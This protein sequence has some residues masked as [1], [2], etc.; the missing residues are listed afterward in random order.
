MTKLKGEIKVVKD[1]IKNLY[2]EKVDSSLEALYG[3]EIALELKELGFTYNGFAPKTVAIGTW[4]E[5]PYSFLK[6]DFRVGAKGGLFT[7]PSVNA[8]QKKITEGK[9]LNIAETI[10]KGQIE[11][12]EGAVALVKGDVEK[13]K[14]FL[15]G[16]LEMLNYRKRSLEYKVAKTQ[17]ALL[18]T[19]KWFADIDSE[20]REVVVKDSVHGDVTASIVYGSI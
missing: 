11:N 15:E 3:A 5:E 20:C 17:F 13:A 1:F 8:V 2:G 19:K 18:L 12:C 9:N 16:N 6:I 7:L 4:G 10:M 14:K